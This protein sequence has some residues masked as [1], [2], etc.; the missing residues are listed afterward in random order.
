MGR[1]ALNRLFIAEEF[2]S[3]QGEGALTGVHS[4][5]VRVAG[6]P[7]RCVWCDEPATS[8]RP[9]GQ[10]MSV[11]D[12]AA[13]AVAATEHVVLTGGEPLAQNASASFAASVRDAGRHLTVET[14]GAVSPPTSFRCDLASVSPKLAHSRPISAARSLL[15]RHD[16]LRIQPATIAAC[17]MSGDEWQLKFVVRPGPELETDLDELEALLRALQVNT[18]DRARRVFLIPEGSNPLVLDAMMRELV[19]ACIARG[20]RLGGRLHL[21]LFGNTPGT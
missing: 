15:A 19:T 14:S 18:M 13:R 4:A 21:T 20:L 17:L 9:A 2:T 6:C 16:R 7:L 5:F 3:I 10:W 12:V 8:W 11:V 1:C